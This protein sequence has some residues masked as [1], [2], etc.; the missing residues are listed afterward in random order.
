MDYVKPRDKLRLRA[1]H[2]HWPAFQ[3]DMI[4]LTVRSSFLGNVAQTRHGQSGFGRYTYCN[5][6]ALCIVCIERQ[7]NGS[8]NRV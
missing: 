4:Q 5:D 3:V 6:A 8:I 1:V 7:R 2:T